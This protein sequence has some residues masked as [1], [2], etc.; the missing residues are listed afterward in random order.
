KTIVPK[1][2]D[3]CCQTDFVVTQDNSSAT[4][5]VEISIAT[6][7]EIPEVHEVSTDTD[8]FVENVRTSTS[9]GEKKNSQFPD[10]AA[11]PNPNRKSSRGK[12]TVAMQRNRDIVIKGIP[13]VVPIEE[14]QVDLV[15]YNIPVTNISRLKS[16]KRP[17]KELR[18]VTLTTSATVQD[19]QKIKTILG[20]RIRIEN[21]VK[22]IGKKDRYQF[23]DNMQRK[24]H[25]CL[26][27]LLKVI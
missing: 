21:L 10:A 27:T 17:N 20:F 6:Q 14:I 23:G 11:P 22:P 7:T 15:S 19:L 9:V 24:L 1:T 25:E 3:A 4:D 13:S 2:S 26:K 8:F 12:E 5:F 16:W 18:H